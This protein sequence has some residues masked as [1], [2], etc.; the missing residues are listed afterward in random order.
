MYKWHYNVPAREFV[1]YA[2]N[3]LESHWNELA[4]NKDR[5]KLNPDVDKYQTLMDMGYLHN[6]AVECEGEIIAYSVVIAQ[7]HLHYSNNVFAMV[8]VIYVA[9]SHRNSRVG[10]E[11]IN[12]TEVMAMGLG[13]DVL[14]YH[15]K[16]NHPAIEKI[17]YKKGYS[18]MENIIGKF[19]GV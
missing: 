8:D 4:N 12:K 6:I 11:L 17:L 5:I 10:I 9:E 16:P 19:V 15:T 3:S 1:A 7:P 2:A 14:T 13:A 18:H